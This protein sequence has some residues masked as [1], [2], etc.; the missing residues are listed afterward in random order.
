MP[1][2]LSLEGVDYKG[3]FTYLAKGE[4]YTKQ[5]VEIPVIPGHQQDFPEKGSHQNIFLQPRIRVEKLHSS[6][7]KFS[8]PPVFM[9]H[10]P[11]IVFIL[12]NDW[13]NQKKSNIS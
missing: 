13:K 8:L 6:T 3:N 12:L 9:V 4:L 1:T 2:V 10:E 7:A 11:R 5:A